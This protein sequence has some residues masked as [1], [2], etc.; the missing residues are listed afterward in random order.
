MTTPRY[1]L[2]DQEKDRR[3]RAWEAANASVRM[4]G[5]EISDAA[6]ELQARHI[7]GEVA[8]DEVKAWLDRKFAAR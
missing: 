1:P 3:R 8:L 2:P 7:E 5:G 6:L 4:E